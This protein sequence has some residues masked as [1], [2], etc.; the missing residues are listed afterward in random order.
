MI[1]ANILD[2]IV[3]YKKSGCKFLFDME[4]KVDEDKRGEKSRVVAAKPPTEAE[5]NLFLSIRNR[6]NFL[7]S[8]TTSDAQ[9]EELFIFKK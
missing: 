4:A 6:L 3:L 2:T 8:P 7:L 5:I 1:L 9:K